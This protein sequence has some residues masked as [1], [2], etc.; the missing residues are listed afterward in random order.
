MIILFD[1]DGTLIDSTE[2]ILE[3]FNRSFKIHNHPIQK[4]EKIKEL[5]GYPLDIMYEKLG[6]KTCE[7]DNFIS[8]YKNHYKDIS[9]EKT[10]LLD[11]AIEAI[12]LAK[13]FATLGIV[14]TKTASYSKV[15]MQHFKL[16]Q[17]F[18]VLIGREDV[19]YP[20][21][22]S[23]PIEMALE[24]LNS[25]NMEVWMIGDTELDI[26]SANN[27]NINS[28]GV[29]SG[30]GSHKSLSKYTKNIFKNTLEAVTYLQNRKK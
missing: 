10:V 21:P 26:I 14:T 9:T 28:A 7:I 24:K 25:E 8:T 15:L 2:A 12:E 11:G 16:M 13:E 5:I 19:E 29:L 17:H 20:K 23:Q 6:V 27:A 4:D 22:H 1:L 30:Y 18:D 3:S